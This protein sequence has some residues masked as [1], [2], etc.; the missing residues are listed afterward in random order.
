MKETK[1]TDE[2]LVVEVLSTEEV[3]SKEA[4]EQISFTNKN[5]VNIKDINYICHYFS[6]I[7]GCEYCPIN[8]G[9]I[10]G[11]ALLLKK[12]GS[13]HEMNQT[14]LDWLRDNPPTSFLMDIK[15]KMP[16]IDLGNSN[17]PSFCV[18]SIYGKDCCNCQ[19]HD[20]QK[21][22]KENLVCRNCWKLPIDKEVRKEYGL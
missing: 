22:N 1:D 20:T 5:D 6:E 15:E 12:F 21:F 2:K 8:S 9:R 17:T 7:E 14:L 4:V 13:S 19:L 10:C 3:L 18:Q 16:N 11:Y